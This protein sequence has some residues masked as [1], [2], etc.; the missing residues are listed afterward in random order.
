MHTHIDRRKEWRPFPRAL[1]L[2]VVPEA[3]APASP[4]SSLEMQMLGPTPDLLDQN[5]HFNQI[6]G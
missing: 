2:A 5:L 6:P 1:L 3:A 4:G